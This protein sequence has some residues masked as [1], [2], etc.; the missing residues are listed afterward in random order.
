MVAGYNTGGGA[1]L[2]VLVT[3][4]GVLVICSNPPPKYSVVTAWLPPAWARPAGDHAAVSIE[5]VRAIAAACRHRGHHMGSGIG[6]VAVTEEWPA[7]LLRL[8]A[9]RPVAL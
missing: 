4:V 2:P 3:V 9:I 8:L 1:V 6:P 5:A 7:L